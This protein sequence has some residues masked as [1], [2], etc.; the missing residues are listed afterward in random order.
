VVQRTTERL[1][2]SSDGG[3]RG[4]TFRSGLTIVS[5]GQV[6]ANRYKMA[7]EPNEYQVPAECGIRR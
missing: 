7:Q 5:H 4:A 3:N 2:R 1:S 6:T